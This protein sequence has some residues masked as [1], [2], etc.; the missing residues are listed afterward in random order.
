MDA[1]WRT[2]YSRMLSVLQL[3]AHL[4]TTTF[5]VVW[6]WIDDDENRGVPDLDERCEATA[7]TTVPATAEVTVLTLGDS[8]ASLIASLVLA[9]DIGDSVATGTLELSYMPVST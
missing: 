6:L 8:T 9:A 2:M 4:I 1:N 7:P 5:R 3:D